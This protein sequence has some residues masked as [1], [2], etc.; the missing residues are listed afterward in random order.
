MTANIDS[1]DRF[2]CQVC[3]THWVVPSLARDCALSH[4]QPVE[5]LEHPVKVVRP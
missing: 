2:E 1:L 3:G 5:W 4:V